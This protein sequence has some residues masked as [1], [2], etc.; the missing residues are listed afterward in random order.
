MKAIRS[1]HIP[2]IIAAL[3]GLGGLLMAWPLPL[4]LAD[5]IPGDGFDGWQNLWNLWWVERALL[6]GGGD[7]WHTTMLDYPGGVSLLFHT[8]NLPNGFLS[9]PI[10]QIGGLIPAYNFVVFL[11]FALGGLGAYLLVLRVMGEGSMPTRTAAL[12]AGAVYAYSPFHFAHLLGH[13]QVFSFQ[14][15]PFY[16]LTLY[17]LLDGRPDRGRSWRWAAVAVAFLILAALTDWYNLVYLSVLTGLWALWFAWSAE[18]W[19]PRG[20]MLALPAAVMAAA[21]MVLGPLLLPMAREASRADYMVTGEAHIVGL[22]A[23]L[24]GLVL[25]QEMHPIWGKAVAEIAGRFTSSTS[26]RMLSLGIAPLLL[27]VVGWWAGGRR[28]RPF[29]WAGLAF[30]V[31]ALGP[32]LHVTGDEV[33]LNDVPVVLPGLALYRWIPFLA[34]ARSVGR[35]AVMA[36]LAVAVLSALGLRLLSARLGRRWVAAPLVAGALVLVEFLPAPYPLSASDMP[37]WYSTLAGEAPGAILNLPV[38]W[39]RPQYLL[40]QTQHERPLT[41]GYTSRRNPWSPVESYPGLQHLRR[42]GDDVL[43]FPDPATFATIA[44]DLGLRYVVLDAYQMPGGEERAVTQ[45][46]AAALLAGRAPVYEDDRLIVYRLDPPSVARA[47]AYLSGAW[48]PTEERPDG[49]WQRERCPDCDVLGK[50]GAAAADFTV[51]CLGV[52]DF[53]VGLEPG[54]TTSLLEEHPDCTVLTS[55]TW[56]ER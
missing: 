1:A 25:P 48:E 47:Y 20:T 14:W 45:L 43:A 3:Y 11:S 5:A 19:R 29:V 21:L 36:S 13:M 17:G 50:T 12:V 28:S 31:L 46:L 38:N 52:P 39:D 53:V 8:L 22:S 49:G 34:I 15:L 41:S 6:R 40:Y 27:A 33:R 42:L 37:S 18:G 24:L 9:L 35:Y 56:A 44:A 23:D 10:Q 51:T 2:A 55:V 54:R 7:L 16:A 4:H 30:T 26:E 32:V